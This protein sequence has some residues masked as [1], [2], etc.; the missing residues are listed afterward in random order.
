MAWLHIDSRGSYLWASPAPDEEQYCY[1]QQTHVDKEILDCKPP[2]YRDKD[3]DLPLIMC[4][5]RP[6]WVQKSK[7]HK[8]WWINVSLN[9]ER[10]LTSIWGGASATAK[11][12]WGT[13]SAISQGLWSRE[14]LDWKEEGKDQ[15]E[16][17]RCTAV[18][19]CVCAAWD[20]R[21]IHLVALLERGDGR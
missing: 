7:L 15:S 13:Y 20:A 16:I 10:Q 2:S 18:Y 8:M 1:S 6:R 3:S 4:I 19:P 11:L 17:I 14:L 5:P 21:R 9:A 12:N